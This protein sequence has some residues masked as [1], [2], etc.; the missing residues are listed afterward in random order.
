MHRIAATGQTAEGARLD[1]LARLAHSTHELDLLVL[2]D[3]R[4]APGSRAGIG[5][6]FQRIARQHRQHRHL[7]L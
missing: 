4:V 2:L 3:R 6:R 1:H 7:R 5:A